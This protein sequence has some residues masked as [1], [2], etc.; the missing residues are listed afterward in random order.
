MNTMLCQINSP[1]SRLVRMA[2]SNEVMKKAFENSKAWANQYHRHVPPHGYADQNPGYLDRVSA[3]NEMMDKDLKYANK[4]EGHLYF[5]EDFACQTQCIQGQTAVSMIG[6]ERLKHKKAVQ[7]LDKFLQ[8]KRHDAEALRGIC[9]ILRSA[10]QDDCEPQHCGLLDGTN[11]TEY[12]LCSLKFLDSV[13][14]D[15]VDILDK[16]NI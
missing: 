13:P 12:D 11:L 15:G 10:G 8:N 16:L 6:N 9:R 1:P 5:L 14:T 2:S 4:P 3:L 7:I